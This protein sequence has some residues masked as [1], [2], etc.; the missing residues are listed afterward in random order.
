M[1]CWFVNDDTNLLTAYVYLHSYNDIDVIL[2]ASINII[3]AHHFSVIQYNYWTSDPV[4][5]CTAC[6][7]KNIKWCQNMKKY[8][9]SIVQGISTVDLLK[10]YQKWYSFGL[11]QSFCFPPIKSCTICRKSKVDVLGEYQK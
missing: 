6:I 4:H 2:I 9:N 3:I 11:Y 10:D 1:P 7:V 5:I 8:P